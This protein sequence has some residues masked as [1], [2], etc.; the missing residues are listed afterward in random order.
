MSSGLT[1][2]E[3]AKRLATC[4]RNEV[5]EEKESLFR[6]VAKHF[7]AP[8]PWMLEATIVVQLSFGER[9][10]A[11][12]ITALLVFNVLLGVVQESRADAALA[13]L[14]RQLTLKARVC[15]DDHWIDLSA[16]ELVPDDLVQLSLGGIVPADLRIVSGSVLLDQSMLTGELIPSESE[17]GGLAYAGAIVRRGQATGIV[18]A[19]GAQTYFG[20][21]AELVRVA[22]V[23][24]TEV[25]A[26]VGLVRNL[27]V[28]N[29]A[30]VIGMLI[31]A[32]MIALP[33]SQIILL[34]ITAMLSAVPVAL[35]ATFTLGAALG[36][37]TLASRG[38]LLTRLSA[39]H[40]AASIDVLCADKTGTL[41]NNEL[42]VANVHP[43]AEGW[44]EGDV[45]A[46]AALASAPDS[47]DPVDAAIH[48]AAQSASSRKPVPTLC[49]FKP[50]DPSSKRAEASV[51][52]GNG[53]MITVIKGAPN[54]VATACALTN[55]ADKVITD[56]SGAGY[57]V[58]AVAVGEH[59]R[60]QLVG[61]IALNDPPRADS[62]GLLNEL[63][64]IGVETVMVTGDAAPTAET[65]AR[66]IG[67]NGAVCPPGQIPPRVTPADYAVYAGVFPEDKFRLV[68]AFQ[69]AGHAVGMCGDGA[70][71]APALRQAQIGIAV[72]TA[73]DVAKAAAGVVLTQPGLGGIVSVVDEGRAVFHRI[74]TYTLGILVNKCV[75]LLVLGGGLLLTGHAVLTPMLQAISMVAGDFVSMARTADR[76]T[77][78]RR[79]NTWRLRNLTLAA[80]PLA[81]IKLGF[82][83]S[84]LSVG[85]LLLKL[86]T[87]QLQTLTLI[88]LVFIGQALVFVL[89]ERGRFWYSRP[90]SVL[91]LF[92]ATDVIVMS[93]LA[94][95]GIFMQAIPV[96]V[97]IALLVSVAIFGVL[98]DQVKLLVLHWVPID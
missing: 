61:L 40:E 70:N 53:Q 24:S 93:L 69:H 57:R 51:R 77:P 5:T 7:W 30:I 20:R 13:L 64:H 94:A 17:E 16:S 63:R 43:L 6:R 56:L 39:L 52:D 11:A 36:A 41:T 28:L 27:S 1:S 49:A 12:L 23:E 75:T 31:Y 88:M 25:K 98:M 71:D 33:A 86:S 42:G 59:G 10:E 91:V 80:I 68:Q 29:A 74:L 47:H 65:V 89:R 48:R 72:S 18:N 84:V 15:R 4:G 19:T 81:C 54:A 46:F 34:V 83:I 37:R 79:P 21:T 14:K 62:P 82:C 66:A 22:R 96:W 95:S 44:T 45:L 9:I 35:P 73:T 8:V 32:Q 97:I 38:V 85:A 78:S 92:S 76:A 55:E 50:F 3:A 60:M 58:L 2:A 67:L 26:V 90:S 87:A